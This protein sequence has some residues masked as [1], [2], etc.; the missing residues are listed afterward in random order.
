MKRFYILFAIFIAFCSWMN[1]ANA[2]NARVTISGPSRLQGHPFDIDIK[3]AQPVADN[4]FTQSDIIVT[5]PASKGAFTGALASYTLRLN[6]TGSG[7]VTVRIPANTSYHTTGFVLGQ[8]HIHDNDASNTY[9]VAVVR[10]P[11][12]TISGTPSPGLVDTF[13]VTIEFSQAVLGILKTDVHLSGDA[14]ASVTNVDSV[15]T[16]EY[17]ATIKPTTQGTLKIQVPQ[18]AGLINSFY[19]IGNA[20]SEIFTVDIDLAPRVT[21]IGWPS[22]VSEAGFSRVIDLYLAGPSPG[23]DAK[24]SFDVGITFSEDV[25]NFTAKGIV[26][27]GEANAAVTSL[28]GSKTDYTATI[29]ATYI[30]GGGGDGTLTIAVPASAAADL[31]DNDNIEYLTEDDGTSVT[32]GFRPTLEITVPEEP[33][34]GDF[35]I[36]LVFSEPIPNFDENIPNIS[37]YLGL[38]QIG[39]TLQGWS[40]NS[41]MSEFTATIAPTSDGILPRFFLSASRLPAAKNSIGLGIAWEVRSP[42]TVVVDVTQPT[43]SIVPMDVQNDEFDVTIT[44]TEAVNGFMMSGIDLTGTATA[45]VTALSGGGAAYTAT[46]TPTADGTVII[47]IPANSAQDDAGNGNELF[48]SIPVSVDLTPPG[49]SIT[50][51]PTVTNAAFDVTIT[52]TEAVTGFVMSDIT[53]TGTA[54]ASVTALSGSGAAYTATITPTAAGDVIIGIPANSAQDDAGNGNELFTSIPVS[55]DLTPPGV[56]ITGAPTV[57]NAAFDV[58]ITFTEAVT[59]FVMSDITLTGS[60]ATAS[61]TALSGSGAAYTATITPTTAGDVII[62]IPANSAQDD[63]GN[64]NE[65]FTSIPVSVDLTPPGVS[66]DGP[67]VTNAAF[68][69]TITFTEAVNGFVM[70]DITLTGSTAT[71]SVTALS[72]S[73]AAYTAT[74]TPTAAGDVIIGIPANSAQDDAGNGNELFTSIPVSVDLT[75]PGVSSITGAPTVTNAPFTVTITFTED[76]NGFMMSD[77]DLTGSTATASVTALSGSGAAYTA[78]ITPTTAGDVIIKIPANS[79]QDDAGNGNTV[80][81]GPTVVYDTSLPGILSITGLP[82]ARNTTPFDVTIT[83]SE[84]VT[85]FQLSDVD[86]TAGI[87]TAVLI[88]QSPTTVDTVAYAEVY[89]L[90]VTPTGEGTW[91]LRVPEGVAE[92]ESGNKNVASDISGV[93]YDVVF[94]FTPPEVAITGIPETP[95]IDPF[96]VTITFTEDVTGFTVDDILISATASATPLSGSGAVYTTEITPIGDVEGEITIQIPADVAQDS[97]D[98]NNEASPAYSV[99]VSIEWMPDKNLRDSIRDALGLPTNSIFTRETLLDLTVLNTAEIFLDAEDPRIADLT[100]LEYATELTELYLNENAISDLSPLAALTQ[101]TVLSLNDNLIEYIWHEDSDDNPFIDLTQLIMLSLDGNLIWDIS[102]LEALPQLTELSLNRNQIEDISTLEALTQLTALS[103]NENPI[104]D[105]A[106]L[107]V[108]TELTHLSLNANAIDDISFC[109][110][111]TQLEN[112]YLENNEIADVSPLAGLE[113]LKLLKLTGNPIGDTTPLLG[114]ARH[115]EADEPFPALIFDEALAEI[116]REIFDLDTEEQITRADLRSLTELEASDS[117]IIDLNGLEHATAIETLDLRGNTIEDITPLKGLKKLTTLDLGLNSIANIEALA[118]LTALT[119]LSLEENAIR[120]LTPLAA[121]VNLE[122][123]RLTGNPIQDATPLTDLTADIKVDIAIPDIVRDPNLATAIREVLDL[124]LGTRITSPIVRNLTTLD[125]Q[126]GLVTTLSGLEAAT[127]LSSLSIGNAAITN[128]QSLEGLTQLTSLTINGGTISDITP[129]QDMHQLTLLGLSSN[130]IDNITPLTALTHLTT[131]DLS[132]NTINGIEPLQNLTGLRT[133]NLSGNTINGIEPLQN[134]TGLRTLNLSGNTISNVEPLQVLTA[135]TTL[136]L[137]G[138]GINGI[139]PL[140]TLTALTTL[141]LSDNGI[142][143]VEP[144]QSMTRLTTLNLSG[145]TISTIAPLQVLTEL[146]TL[147]LSN[148]SISSINALQALTQLTTLDLSSNSL[149]DIQPLQGLMPLKELDLVSNNISDVSPLAG[150][151]NLELLRLAEN[152]I[153]DTS[154]LFAL[155]TVHKLTDVDIEISQWAPW[156]VNQDGSVNDTDSTLVA[157]AMG[158]IAGTIVDPRTDVNSDGIVDR[159]DLLLVTKYLDNNVAGAPSV[160]TIVT[161]L[162]SRTL[163]SLDRGTL[164][165]E[166]NRLIV[167]SDGSLK[168]QHAIRFLQNFLLALHPD[169]TRLLANYPNPFNPETW[170]PYQLANASR[171][172]LIIYDV[173]STIVRRLVLG[174]QQS[175]YYVEKDRAAYWDGRNSVGERVASGIYFYQLRTD[176]ISALR[177]MVILK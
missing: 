149:I 114:I 147:T 14:E 46:I 128:I 92:D 167:E 6:S 120:D 93:V 131:L 52:F 62:K 8:T 71:A 157:A 155:V 95:Q 136:N 30:D 176:N 83:F 16:S 125:T 153:M 68:D 91:T 35:D 50:D 40:E 111:L 66:I 28:T 154:P 169:K 142:T 106:L 150:L 48:T 29:T 17:I 7:D 108:L 67:T 37:N 13:D 10:V 158:Q 38:A 130:A 171:V 129:L 5:G 107:E 102:P 45:S 55:V 2:G 58:T 138:N 22:F 168:Y 15:T 69:V 127:G 103:L 39:A 162:G 59:G 134:L 116:L 123:L 163:K 33:Q 117:D 135:L 47:G 79:A 24:L 44:F 81:I 60:T 141:N 124:P 115:I 34:N 49:V 156:D 76:V 99:A 63:A 118:G 65:L 164:E 85:G 84:P 42:R 77:I 98:N 173:R 11:T 9:T 151:V 70:S 41:D 177:K 165:V 56:S 122:I 137:D 133:L 36:I 51:G 146:T 82:E 110:A 143:G 109:A 1:I 94:D 89:T 20:A 97:G 88:A 21:S 53:L 113:N 161:L 25:T 54:T 121:L 31:T 152:P 75:P 57:T 72:G 74:I 145:N 26:L 96:P 139:L 61:V 64:G 3:F 27:G 73:G 78:T 140:Q 104:D 126:D 80:L 170:I 132:G 166:L 4:S 86:A 19:G 144:L 105:F 12:V 159:D 160:D 18:D 101:L 32:I 87:Y 174:Y 175:G 112:L 23:Q 90:R 172:E 43:V 100:G 119:E 148:N